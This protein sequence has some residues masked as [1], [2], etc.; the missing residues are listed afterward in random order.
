MATWTDDELNRIGTAEELDIMPRRN[1]GSLKKPVTIWVMRHGDDLYVRSYRGRN[2]SWYQAV[3]AS[4]HARIRAAGIEK[5]V[6]LTAADPALSEHIDAA[7]Q[8]KYGHYP[9]YVEPMLTPEV[10]A[11]TLK[12]LPEETQP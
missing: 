2:G 12:L 9:Q 5:D 1:D 4:Q 3:R 11:T 6:T 10:R 7:Y 8:S